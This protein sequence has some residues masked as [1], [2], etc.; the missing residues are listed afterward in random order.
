MPRVLAHHV[1]LVG[2]VSPEV[3]RTLLEQLRVRS[4]DQMRERLCRRWF[5]GPAH[6][7]W[8]RV[9]E[10]CDDILLSLV[11]DAGCTDRDC[12]D[13]WLREHDRPCSVCRPPRADFRPDTVQWRPSPNTTGTRVP[14]RPLSDP[15]PPVSYQVSPYTLREPEGAWNPADPDSLILRARAA[16][17]PPVHRAA[18]RQARKLK[19]DSRR[20]STPDPGL[21][22]APLRGRS[23]P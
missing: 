17:N 23:T 1:N 6:L 20:A 9:G 12:E 19:N 14:A 7:S 10:Q 13:G 4:V 16:L 21:G 8:K 11:A 15:P 18:L 3:R 2:G 22:T 5:A